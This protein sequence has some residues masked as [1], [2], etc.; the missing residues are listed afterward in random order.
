MI[1][2]DSREIAR[3][4]AGG[5]LNLVGRLAGMT[6]E[7][8]ELAADVPLPAG[9]GAR[10]IAVTVAGMGGSGFGGDVLRALLA[11]AAPMPI[12]TIKDDRLPAFVGVD[13]LTFVCSYSGNTDE[14][15]AAYE[16]AHTAG[17]SIIAV[18]SGGA[19]ADRARAGRHPVVR[20]P[21]GLPPRAALPYLLMPMLRITSRLG[22]AATDDGDVRQASTVL[23]ELAARWAPTVPTRDNPCKRLAERLVGSIPV[24]YAAS[25]A[26]EPVAYRWKTQIN[27]NSK[28]FATWN[29]F[30]ELSHN[31]TVGWTSG[32]GD[33]ALFVVLL[34]DRDDGALSTLQIQATRTL[35]FGRARGVE[36]VWSVGVGLLARLLSLVM[37]GDFVSVYLAICNGVDPTPIDV[38]TEMKRRMQ[39]ASAQRGTI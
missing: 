22:I 11:P 16:E 30:P 29:V 37:F 24:I 26:T 33:A 20:V 12:L 2:D 6:L 23:A 25:Q 32:V 39:E 27:E 34:R 28:M 35:A 8:W 4:D 10:P 7:G 1:L 15:L 31:E 3:I 17:A 14:T 5:M 38:I 19:L 21:G 18:T 13:T 36:S 9:A